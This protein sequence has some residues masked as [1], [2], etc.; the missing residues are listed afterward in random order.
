MSAIVGRHRNQNFF[1]RH[2]L[3]QYAVIYF[4]TITNRFVYYKSF[5]FV[6][7]KSLY[8]SMPYYNFYLP[9]YNYIAH[10]V[11]DTLENDIIFEQLCHY[12]NI[13]WIIFPLLVPGH[14]PI[15]LLVR[16]KLVIIEL[17]LRRRKISLH[18]AWT[19]HVTP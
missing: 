15:S 18:T 10:C 17:G 19:A 7:C 4:I 14:V 5:K 2:Y 1:S 12:G 6:Y 16:K 13:C 8:M 3:M 9:L 11:L